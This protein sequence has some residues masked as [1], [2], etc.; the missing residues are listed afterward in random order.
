VGDPRHPDLVIEQAQ[1]DLGWLERG[2]FGPRI[3]SGSCAR[4]F[5][6]RCATGA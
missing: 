3:G 4:A 6:A 1:V 5:M 2:R